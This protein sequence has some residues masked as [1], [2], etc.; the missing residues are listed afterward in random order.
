MFNFTI[1][2]QNIGNT[3]TFA[4]VMAAFKLECVAE[5]IIQCG[6][7]ILFFKSVKVITNFRNP[8]FFNQLLWYLWENFI[9]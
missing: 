5:I 1:A 3:I 6:A 2:L 8:K 4:K 7:I 9:C